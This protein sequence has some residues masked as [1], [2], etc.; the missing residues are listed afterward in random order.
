MTNAI[1]ILFISTILSASA[2]ANAE[3]TETDFDA[4]SASIAQ[5]SESDSNA[6]QT[7]PLSIDKKMA[8]SAEKAASVDHYLAL[9]RASRSKQKQKSAEK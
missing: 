8:I 9:L 2:S 6:N 1:K 4:S 5:N 7:Q 3:N